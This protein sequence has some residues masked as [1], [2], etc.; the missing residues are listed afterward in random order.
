M[1]II[2]HR[3]YWQSKEERNELKAFERSFYSGFGVETDIRDTNGCLVVCHD[4]PIKGCLSVEQLFALYLRTGSDLPLAL[5]IKA[6]GL[7][8]ELK[9]L[10]NKYD[11]SN[12][13][14]FDMSVPD[15]L[16]Y[17]SEGLS[18]F[19]RQSE[20]EMI[21]S[22]YEPADGVWIDSFQHDWFNEEVIVRHLAEAKK[23]CLVSPELHGRDHLPLWE[24]LKGYSI[25][26]TSD[27]VL[28]TDHPEE[29]R[30]FFYGSN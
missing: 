29:A 4:I 23:V 19:T 7:Q 16:G 13:F 8:V 28:C 21:P 18:F 11:I 12:Y 9:K 1:Q 10:I 25:I 27:L 2:S 20:F 22:L 24:R 3:G 17:I 6:D 5:N 15:T 14:V 26:S 30:R